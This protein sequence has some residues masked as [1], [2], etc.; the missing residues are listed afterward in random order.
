MYGP[1]RA[2]LPKQEE[3]VVI[4]KVEPVEEKKEQQIQVPKEEV[5]ETVK[6]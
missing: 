4:K 5:K 2:D 6:T 1:T 3:P